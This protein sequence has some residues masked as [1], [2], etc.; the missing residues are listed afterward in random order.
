MTK[1]SSKVIS[2]VA[3]L[4]ENKPISSAAIER[5]VTH[6]VGSFVDT[7]NAEDAI[8]RLQSNDGFPNLKY[9]NHRMAKDGKHTQVWLSTFS[10]EYTINEGE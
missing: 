9:V 5:R 10:S 4:V 7:K 6:Y 3:E 1:T 8:K 2:K